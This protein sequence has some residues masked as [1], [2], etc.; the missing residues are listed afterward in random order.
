M[1]V[2]ILQFGRGD[3]IESLLGGGGQGKGEKLVALYGKNIYPADVVRDRQ[4]RQAASE[5]V[6][7]AVMRAAQDAQKN[8]TAYNPD[9][10]DAADDRLKQLRGFL[11]PN[12]LLQSLMQERR[13]IDD[14]I[15]KNVAELDAILGE[16]ASSDKTDKGKAADQTRMAKDLRLLFK[17]QYLQFTSGPGA[18][19][20]GGGVKDEDILDFEIWK[21]QADKL[22]VV[23]TKADARRA[24][25]HEAGDRDLPADPG[26]SWAADP[27][28]KSVLDQHPQM[29][30]DQLATAVAD[31]FRVEIAQNLLAGRGAGVPAVGMP[32]LT[33]ESFAPYDFWTYFRDNRTTV[34]AAFL[35][36]PV[37]AFTDKVTGAP[38]G[39]ELDKLYN[40]YR[41]KVPDPNSPT[42]G[43]K[44]PRRIRIET[45]TAR[46]DSDYYKELVDRVQYNRVRRAFYAALPGNTAAGGVVPWLSLAGALAGDPVSGFRVD[47]DQLAADYGEALADRREGAVAAGQLAGLVSGGPAAWSAA[48]ALA[49]ASAD[50]RR[51]EAGRMASAAFRLALAGTASG[52]PLGGL[53]GSL[54]PPHALDGIN[55]DLAD[56]YFWDVQRK[57][58]AP[59]IIN[60]DLEA[61]VKALPDV[62]KRGR[63]EA[64]QK[65]AANRAAPPVEPEQYAYD[66]AED[67]IRAE[68]QKRGWDLNRNAGL[69]DV[70]TTQTD[71]AL[72][73][74]A[75]AYSGG[76]S[77]FATSVFT[78]KDTGMYQ[79][80]LPPVTDLT[81]T[82]IMTY[83]VVQD[84]R[85]RELSKDEAMNRGLLMDAWRLQEARKLAVREAEE[86]SAGAKA[87]WDKFGQDS[88][89]RQQELEKFLKEKQ[90]A[91]KLGETFELPQPGNPGIAR[92]VNFLT[93]N[94]GVGGASYQPYTLPADKLPNIADN[95]KDIYDPN[96]LVNRLLALDA[97]GKTLIFTDKPAKTFYVAVVEQR[98]V[99]EFRGGEKDKEFL[100]AYQD[101]SLPP[102]GV[103]PPQAGPMWRR[104]FLPR[105]KDQFHQALIRQLREEAGPVNDQGQLILEKGKKQQ[106]EPNGSPSDQGPPPVDNPFS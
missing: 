43:F 4:S 58:E 61:F 48:P 38:D 95:P 98:V 34:K 1:V 7:D 15:G 5:L 46:T 66:R 59:Q 37:Q 12:F 60:A 76:P 71:P 35:P 82:K 106:E 78:A 97:P 69:D 45:I 18:L 72:Q 33:A 16:L 55:A 73:P 86:I 25:S 53:A 63:D 77:A 31:E 24:V 104:F 8:V 51:Q 81:R 49:Q 17:F 10:P 90:A 11:D 32:D 100:V 80:H 21:H 94:V 103:L 84:E 91:D 29:T 47:G 83:W 67:F 101:A 93:P 79:P 40:Q 102:P 56:R 36:I 75:T 27:L 57:D 6:Q 28:I 62:I 26:A 88:Q 19:Y 105:R 23:L 74:L 68:A 92:L 13:S 99:P 65:N 64:E 20:F 85:E 89:G 50:D 70:Y 44:E 52:A 9:K 41:S 2:F 14:V 30:E 22:G 3:L 42:P 54:L 87:A 39:G 96:N